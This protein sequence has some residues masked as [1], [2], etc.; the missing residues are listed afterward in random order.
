VFGGD[1]TGTGANARTLLST[2][3]SALGAIQQTKNS[4]LTAAGFLNTSASYLNAVNALGTHATAANG[5]SVVAASAPEAGLAYHGNGFGAG[6]NYRAS[7]PFTA[8]QVVGQDVPFYAVRLAAGS[9]TVSAPVTTFD[10]TF[11]LD[12]ATGRLTYATAPV[13]EPGTYAL[14]GMGLLAMGALARRRKAV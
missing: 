6:D 2:S 4:N 1:S 5:A 14:M 10:G 8:S 7:M 13:P 9:S 11:S 3:T 12:A